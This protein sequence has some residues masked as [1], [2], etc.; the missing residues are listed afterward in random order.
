MM[1][2]TAMTKLLTKADMLG[3]GVWQGAWACFADCDISTCGV[4]CTGLALE[5]YDMSSLTFCITSGALGP[6][7]LPPLLLE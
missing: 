2:G 3:S 6:S 5:V 7:P 1:N 4:Q